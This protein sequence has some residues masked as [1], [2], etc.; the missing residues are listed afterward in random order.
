LVAIVL[1][2]A[3]AV[4]VWSVGGWPW[5]NAAASA[6]LLY[7]GIVNIFLHMQGYEA[8]RGW[9]SIADREH[10]AELLF[11]LFWPVFAMPIL[12]SAGFGGMPR[13]RDWFRASFSTGREAYRG[14]DRQDQAGGAGS[15]TAAGA[16]LSTATNYGYTAA[17]AG[18]SAPHAADRPAPQAVDADEVIRGWR[19]YTVLPDPMWV[20]LLVGEYGHRWE[21]ATLT[22]TCASAYVEREDVAEE[23]I[24]R[25]GQPGTP[26]RCGIYMTRTLLA[27]C[28]GRASTFAVL[29]GGRAGAI[30]LAECVA[31]GVVAEGETGMRC[32]HVRI[33]R[34]WTGYPP[35]VRAMLAARY[36]VPVEP[37]EALPES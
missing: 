9:P 30:V 16:Y 13:G 21:T 31:W 3:L 7:I 26:C 32:Q 4:F 10:L 8:Q 34:L 5:A 27:T 23:H 36:G 1:Y 33:E 20:P 18:W 2:A 11:A 25:A 22:A 29:R 24:S 37:M 28:A 12:L 14:R 35:H 6:F 19:A 17:G 15:R